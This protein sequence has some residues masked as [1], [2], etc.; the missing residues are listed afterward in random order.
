MALSFS[1]NF[2][3]SS[4]NIVLHLNPRF[5]ENGWR[6]TTFL[7]FKF[8]VQGSWEIYKR[9]QDP[10]PTFPFANG[11]QFNLKVTA[12]GSHSF[13]LYVDGNFYANVTLIR[14][15]NT[16]TNIEIEVDVLMSF[17]DLWCG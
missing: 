12:T 10:D 15:I 13:E 4:G 8:N 16:I 2:L 5:D 9:L 6:K 7:S 11:Q 17:M 1:I 3:D 14:D